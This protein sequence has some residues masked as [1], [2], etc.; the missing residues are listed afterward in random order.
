MGYRPLYL[1][2]TGA[3]RKKR[4]RDDGPSPTPG[5]LNLVQDITTPSVDSP[6][7]A[8]EH[9]EGSTLKRDHEDATGRASLLTQATHDSVTASTISPLATAGESGQVVATVEEELN[10]E[11]AVIK[12]TPGEQQRPKTLP[13]GSPDD[14]GLYFYLVKPRTSGWD[15]VLIPLSPMDT[16]LV[17]LQNQTV[18]EFP[19]IQVLPYSPDALP[20]GSVTEVQ[21]LTRYKKEAHQ[22]QQ[23]IKEEGEI[24]GDSDLKAEDRNAPRSQTHAINDT[25]SVAM[26]NPS[27]LFATLERDIRG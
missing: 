7:T 6:A 19:S 25:D 27:M 9:I 10:Q 3:P 13:S 15:T 22:M 18:L 12:T 20:V 2:R 24:D 16:F 17:C 21:Y 1:K 5:T 8:K 26:P 14:L 11:D 23:L 4:K